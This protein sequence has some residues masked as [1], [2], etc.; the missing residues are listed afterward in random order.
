[1]EICKIMAL[2]WDVFDCLVACGVF[3]SNVMG[4][5]IVCCVRQRNHALFL[6]SSGGT[7]PAIIK[8][9]KQNELLL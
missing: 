1:M 7:M 8:E 9:P 2:S 3:F 6:R 4:V 5:F